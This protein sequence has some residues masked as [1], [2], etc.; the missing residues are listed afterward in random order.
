MLLRTAIDRPQRDVSFC[1]IHADLAIDL[2]IAFQQL[3]QHI[4]PIRSSCHCKSFHSHFLIVILCSECLE[5]GILTLCCRC[6]ALQIRRECLA[7]TN[8]VVDSL[9]DVQS[10]LRVPLHKSATILR[11]LQ[12]HTIYSKSKAA[13]RMA[14]MGFAM[15][16]PAMSGADP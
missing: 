11:N 16:L 4:A 2:L 15:F 8:D 10:R 5:N 6:R 14:A 12:I 9:V 1:R 3:L 13:E 7:F